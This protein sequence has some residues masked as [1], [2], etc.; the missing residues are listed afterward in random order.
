MGRRG[1]R[2]SVRKTVQSNRRG[3]RVG[4][5]CFEG[6]VLVEKTERRRESHWGR[7][8]IMSPGQFRWVGSHGRGGMW[9]K[10]NSIKRRQKQIIPG[11]RLLRVK[12]QG[13]KMRSNGQKV[14]LR[15][16]EELK[17][18]GL[19]RKKNFK[20]FFAQSSGSQWVTSLRSV[21][22]TTERNPIHDSNAYK[23]RE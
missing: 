19:H 6:A 14:Q 2:G 16:R 23:G 20:T 9:T 13:G 21:R 12:N 22:I 10:K 1:R 5:A 17:R 3:Q 18:R 7:F 11:H 15:E 4:G 8:N